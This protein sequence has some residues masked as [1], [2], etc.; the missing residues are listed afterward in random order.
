AASRPTGC[1]RAARSDRARPRAGHYTLGSGTAPPRG[2]TARARHW[3]SGTRPDIARDASW[4]SI[5]HSAMAPF[6]LTILGAGPAGPNPG[7]VNSGYLLRQGD[8]T[9]LMD[10]GAGTAGRIPLHVPVNRLT[11]VAVSHLHPDHYFDLVALYYMLKY[12]EARAAD[13]S[14]LLPLFVPPGGTEFFRRFGKLIADKPALFYDIFEV[15]DY[16]SGSELVIGGLVFG[17]PPV[18]LSIMYHG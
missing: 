6:T 16:T 17:F 18:R 1:A 11:A 4:A 12:R 3:Y 10:C 7:G 13:V 5:N 15:R 2:T 8:D 14:Q 9:V